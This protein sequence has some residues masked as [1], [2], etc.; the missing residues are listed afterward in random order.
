[1]KLTELLNRITP[2]PWRKLPVLATVLVSRETV[3]DESYAL[4]AANV[5]PEL[6]AAA[7]NLQEN[8]EKNLT[9]PMARLNEALA[10]AEEVNNDS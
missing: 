1:M 9:G 5:L 6:I 4:H 2:L 3:A 7:R 10:L 8:W